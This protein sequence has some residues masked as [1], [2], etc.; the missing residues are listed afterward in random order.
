MGWPGSPGPLLAADGTAL[1]LTGPLWESRHGFCLLLLE[2][3]TTGL[4]APKE[5]S[6]IPSISRCR[7]RAGQIT[8][9]LPSKRAFRG[10]AGP[11][12]HGKTFISLHPIST[13]LSFQA[14]VVAGT[15]QLAQESDS[16]RYTAFLAGSWPMHSL[17]EVGRRVDRP[18]LPDHDSDPQGPGEPRDGLIVDPLQ[19]I[20][21]ISGHCAERVGYSP[22][23]T[24]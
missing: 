5:Q 19:G 15:D 2:S 8:E 12:H 6:W 9:P 17:D 7:M 14:G 21:P 23:A 16:S 18:R 13:A 22:H 24:P 4:G 1:R 20:G 3:L 10:A 11:P